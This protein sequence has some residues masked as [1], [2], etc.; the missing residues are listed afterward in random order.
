MTRFIPSVRGGWWCTGCGSTVRRIGMVYACLLCSACY[1]NYDEPL[2]T[3][4]PFL[5]P[6]C[7]PVEHDADAG[8]DQVIDEV[9]TDSVKETK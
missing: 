3:Y 2:V 1:G 7:T 4:V 6:A 5:V 9:P 8:T